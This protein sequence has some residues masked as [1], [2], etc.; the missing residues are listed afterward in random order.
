MKTRY[1]PLV[2]LKKN[3][4]DESEK[5]VQRAS[6]DLNSALSALEVSYISLS[7]VDTPNGG[8][9]SELLA[10]R[11][12][13]ASQ[14]EVIKHNKEWV[15]YA[16]KQLQFAKEQLKQDLIEYEKFKYLEF[17]EMKKII[18]EQKTK[19]SKELDEIALL[20][21]EQGRRY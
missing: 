12:L 15:E 11:V 10:S 18:Q 9:I 3:K 16:K 14:R 4:M 5:L 21:F 13:I 1:T 7:N 20:T 2:I 8:N 19:E 6:A 17:E